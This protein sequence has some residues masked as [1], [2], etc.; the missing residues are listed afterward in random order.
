MNLNFSLRLLVSVR[1]WHRFLLCSFLMMTYSNSYAVLELGDALELALSADPGIDEVLRNAEGLRS[2]AVA[3]SQL[4]DPVFLLGALNFPVDTFDFDQEPMTQLRVG[5]RQM[6][7]QGNTLSLTEDKLMKKADSVRAGAQVRYLKVY[8]E[9]RQIWLEVLYWIRAAEILDRDLQLFEQLLDVTQSLYS[10]GKVQQQDVLRAELE[11]TR[12]QE[13][14]IRTNRTEQKNRANLARWVGA[15]AR[16]AEWPHDIP[17]LQLTAFSETVY[18]KGNMPPEFGEIAAA[19]R[20]HP[21]LVSL[22]KQVDEAD[23][24]LQLSEAKYKPAWGVEVG[25]G[26]RDGQNLDGSNRSDFFS[27][28]LTMSMPFFTRLRQ[29]KSVEGSFY[30]KQARV[31]AVDEQVLEMTGMVEQLLEQLI[32]NEE[33]L[34]LFDDELLAKSRLQAEAARNAYQSDTASFDEVMRAYLREQRDRLDYQRLL[35]GRQQLI[36]DLQFYFPE[37]VPEL[38]GRSGGGTQ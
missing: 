16:H 17:E 30:R 9:V 32:Q 26:L 1:A 31:Y 6:F 7:P 21:V 2:D 18:S 20:S 33:Q 3:K 8:R 24:D 29:D 11:L 34:A 10:V 35:I 12:L 38:S 19:L 14:L 15:E 5:V 23:L 28:I 22:R 13:K 4:S 36:S 27:A 37:V 25:Y